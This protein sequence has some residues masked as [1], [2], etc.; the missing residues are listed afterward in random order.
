M[1]NVGQFFGRTWRRYRGMR[2]WAQTLI[3]LLVLGLL[4]GPFLPQDEETESASEHRTTTTT[5]KRT[6]TTA[7]R[8]TTTA[9][10][11]TTTTLSLQERSERSNDGT[12]SVSKA[13]F[14][15]DWPLTV[16]G[17]LLSCRGG[18]AIVFGSGGDAY[19]VNGTARGRAADNGWLDIDAIWAPNPEIP[20]TKKDIGPLIDLGLSLC[21]E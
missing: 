19:A 10:P 13:D 12:L 15:D 4:V 20:G 3:A 21:P 8:T 5:E 9:P 7:E 1:A 18:S 14:G 6:T 16:E 2:W 11:R 17:G